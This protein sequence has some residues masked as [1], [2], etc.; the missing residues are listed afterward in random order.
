M[1]VGRGPLCKAAAMLAV[2]ALGIRGKIHKY[3]VRGYLEPDLE[4]IYVY[5]L[6]CRDHAVTTDRYVW[7]AFHAGMDLYGSIHKQMLDDICK[8][9]QGVS[10]LN[11]R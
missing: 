7:I 5:L 9:I 8:R 1:P 10:R 2:A 11:F 4:E 6:E 3:W